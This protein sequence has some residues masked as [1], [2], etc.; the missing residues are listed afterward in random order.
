[1]DRYLA[2]FLSGR[3]GD[4][5]DSRITGVTR[6][7]LFV[8][9]V[10]EGAEGLVPV[11]A[12]GDEY[13]F[14]DEKRHALIGQQTDTVYVLGDQVKVR[15]READGVTG[16]LILDL[17]TEARARPRSIPA[18]DSPRSGGR[19]TSHRRPPHRGRSKSG[20]SGKQPGPRGKPGKRRPRR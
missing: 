1:M 15:L 3:V 14:H 13:F 19:L 18:P 5:F 6:F 11:R 17:L 10:K 7:G 20:P 2:A 8:R 16:G 4:V 12:L 9:L